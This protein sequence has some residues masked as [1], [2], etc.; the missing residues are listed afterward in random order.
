MNTK[1]DLKFPVAP[2]AAPPRQ[3]ADVAAQR[4][5]ALRAASTLN[6]Q[7]L[8]AEFAAKKKKR[9]PR[10]FV[11][12]EILIKSQGRVRYL[13]LSRRLQM[14]LALTASV[15][16]IA[17]SGYGVYHS[18]FLDRAR[19]EI[20]GV[21][22]QAAPAG[23]DLQARIDQLQRDLDAANARAAQAQAAQAQALAQA[24]AQ[25]QAQAQAQAAK[26][27][28]HSAAPPSTAALDQAQARIKALEE[29]RDRVTAEQQE[30]QRRL[31][32]AQQAADA[33]TQSLAQLNRTIESNR[34]ELRQSDNQRAGLQDRVR[35]LEA[36]LA[37]AK[38][39]AGEA[40]TSLSSVEH[41]LQ[42]LSAEHDK[43][44]ADRE[45]LAARL[46][47]LQ[48]RMPSSPTPAP[49]P[50]ADAR[51][52]PSM[53]SLLPWA[54][55]PRAAVDHAPPS[56]QRS[57]NTGDLEQL[58]ASTGIDVEELLGRLQTVPQGQGGPYIALDNPDPK[59]A[60][61]PEAMALRADELQS[62]VKTLPLASP[63]PEY[64]IES[65]FGGRVDPFTRRQAFHAGLDL[66]APYR[67]PVY[68]T[69]PGRVIFTGAKGPYGKVVEIDHGHG[70]VTRFGHLHKP[71]V[72][73][74]QMVTVHQVVGELGSTGRSTGP[75]LH[76]EVLV[77][78]VP[79]DPEKFLQA[80]KNV[81]QTVTSK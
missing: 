26:P 67:S 19:V 46:A 27:P 16:A 31:A 73:R 80:G 20:A 58:I 77:N 74:G 41:K 30:L 55:P 8:E 71:L 56:D 25:T 12:R 65:T 9:G 78:G 28:E 6:V 69:A 60:L 52:A 68:S 54:T 10:L 38:T 11:D 21:L 79:Q 37:T 43:T 70:I 32:A 66:V 81:V 63:L 22:D 49:T 33:K 61:T 5:G 1:R 7:R 24:Q 44:M 2:P 3:S 29:A 62:I 47:E 23:A 53:D 13:T 50:R 36:D 35:Q 72:A 45:Q 4:L 75:H 76:Y 48:G 40:T 17:L 18:S 57:E 34:G 39:Q 14:S 59:A 42:L 15:A 64:R 51:T